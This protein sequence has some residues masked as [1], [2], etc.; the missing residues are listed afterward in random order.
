MT[1]YRDDEQPSTPTHREVKAF[2]FVILAP[3]LFG[4][5]LLIVG[6]TT[7]RYLLAG[8][9]GLLLAATPLIARWVWR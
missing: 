4:L 2:S 8:A 1:G 7:E 5:F 6:F 9:G 3:I